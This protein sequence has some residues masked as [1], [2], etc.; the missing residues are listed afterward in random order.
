MSKIKPTME[1]IFNVE[2]NISKAK[3][4]PIKDKGRVLMIAI[5]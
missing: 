1:K 5:G 3:N 2:L 4:T